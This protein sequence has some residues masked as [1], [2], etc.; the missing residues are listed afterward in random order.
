MVFTP[1]LN[2]RIPSYISP[3]NTKGAVNK[4]GRNIANNQ[5][6][7][8]D[9]AIIEN[10]RTAHAYL[11]NTF[12]STLRQKAKNQSIVV[13]Q[14]LKRRPTVIGKL[15]RFPNMKLARMHDIAGC[16]V[17]FDN[18]ND[19]EVYRSEMHKARFKHI[20]KAKEEDRWN[21]IANPKSS[22]YRGIHDVYEYQAKVAGG[23]AWDGLLLEI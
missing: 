8:G 6:S 17:I 22:G 21:Y 13:A 14:R 4:A 7:V 15:R 9:L 5:Q 11:L 16:R 3:K 19:L 20:R 23:Q 2:K 1:I 12:Q 10:W 18:L